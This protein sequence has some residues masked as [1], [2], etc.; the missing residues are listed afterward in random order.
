MWGRQGHSQV[1]APCRDTPPRGGGDV[2]LEDSFE[3][4]AGQV[5]RSS[6]QE[7]GETHTGVGLRCGK[8]V[9]SAL[10]DPEW[11]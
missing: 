3:G 4:R 7:P 5:G 11:G 8:S 10:G 6:A 1:G 9:P 2:S